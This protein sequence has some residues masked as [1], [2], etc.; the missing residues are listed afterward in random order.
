[1]SKKL[2]KSK[3]P[4]FFKSG[5]TTSYIKPKMPNVLW[6]CF[7]DVQGYEQKICLKSAILDCPGRI[8]NKQLEK[9]L[10]S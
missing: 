7:G 2:L 9:H 3:W 5:R 8:Y 10:V 4:N 1:M 6:T